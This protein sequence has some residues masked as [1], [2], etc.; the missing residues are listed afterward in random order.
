MGRIAYQL[1]KKTMT[2]DE[3]AMENTQ[4]LYKYGEIKKNLNEYNEDLQNKKPPKP[5]KE[6][7]M[8]GLDFE[9]SGQF[10]CPQYWICGNSN[11]GKSH[12]INLLVEAGHRDYMVNNYEWDWKGYQDDLYDFIWFEEYIGHVSINNLN[13]LLEGSKMNLR[14]KSEKRVIKR[15]NLPIMFLSNFLPHEV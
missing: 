6:W 9:F 2:L 13:Q 15:Q 1:M 11:V 12:N 14:V 10:K 7:K 8:F 4:V 5:L 3:A